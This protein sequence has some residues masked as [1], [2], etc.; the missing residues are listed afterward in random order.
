MAAI[1]RKIYLNKNSGVGQLA[2]VIH[3]SLAASF[4]LLLVKGV[5][6]LCLFPSIRHSA[7]MSAGV[8]R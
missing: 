5:R 3:H 8:L 4:S 7:A 1:A 2:K 6:L